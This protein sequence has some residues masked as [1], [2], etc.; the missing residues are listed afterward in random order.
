MSFKP[1]ALS[2]AMVAICS[3]G[4]VVAGGADVTLMPTEVMFEKGTYFEIS[5]AKVTPNVTGTTVAPKISMLPSYSANTLAFKMDLNEKVSVGFAN[6]LSAGINVDYRDTG[7][8]AA[9]VDLSIRSRLLA[10]KY[11][12]NE[13][14][15][16]LGGWKHSKTSNATANVLKNPVGVLTIPSASDSALALGIAYEKPEIALRVSGLYQSATKFDLPMTAAGH[17]SGS[18]V[19]LNGKAGLPK[20]MTLRF[21]SGVAKDTLIFGS[22]HRGDWAKSQIEFETDFSGSPSAYSGKSGKLDARSSF[23]TTTA[24]TL[25]LGR[26]LSEKYAVSATYGWEKGSG[27]TGE[28]LLSTT[29][30]KKSLTLGGKFTSGRLTLSAGYSR[31][32]LGDYTKTTGSYVFSNNKANV[33]GVKLG[34][35]L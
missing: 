34:L 28:S 33:I 16:I 22:V 4:S 12:V 26:K 32:K 15:S 5:S 19:L 8:L 29:N 24:Y 20:S 18:S 27:A 2:M 9:F 17:P 11:Q 23:T 7:V 13:N 6:Y 31:I 1:K 14:L 35:S 21:Q 25:G 3:A 10:V 30:G